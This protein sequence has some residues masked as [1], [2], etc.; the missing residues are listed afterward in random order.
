[1][2]L[3]NLKIAHKLS[4]AFGLVVLLFLLLAGIVHQQLGKVLFSNTDRYPKI[5]MINTI[6]SELGEIA[7]YQRDLLLLSSATEQTELLAKIDRSARVVADTTAQLDP[8]IQLAEGRTLLRAFLDTRNKAIASRTAF[9]EQVRSQKTEEARQTLTGPVRLAMEAQ[10]GAADALLDFQSKLMNESAA[11][12]A[13]GITAAQTSMAVLCGVA[14]VISAGLAFLLTRLIAVPLRKAVEVAR[15]VAAG[16]L[17]SVIVAEGQDETGQLMAA[18]DSMNAALIAIVADVR[19]SAD[20]VTT[21][22]GEIAQGNLDLSSRTE[23]QAS[24]LEETASS[25][26]ELTS[27]VKQNADNARQANQMAASA[28][29]VAQQ[30]GATVGEVVRTMD[31]ISAASRRIVDIIAV[32]DGI[33]FQTNILALNAAVEAARAGEQGRGFAVVA[34]EVR[35]L[36]Q[37]SAAA[38]KEI[39]G[40]I[41]DSVAQVDSGVQQV[42]RAG[43]TMGQIVSGIERVADIMNEISAASREQESGIGEIN[44]AVSAMDSV[45]QQ[46]AALVEEAAAAAQSLRE[47][48]TALSER[49]SV[50]KLSGET[51]RTVLAMPV[52]PALRAPGAAPAPLRSRPALRAV[53]GEWDEF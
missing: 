2:N 23:Q 51:T 3:R 16:D 44:A 20:A 43:D 52:R 34:S 33:A 39:K 50:F 15:T 22:S 48:A 29:Q 8:L 19:Q 5:V 31:A 21:A 25:M 11:E 10:L 46:N 45:T 14:V 30:G 9:L 26:E 47:Q 18:L 12:A 42:G 4:L 32:I 37:R 41:D 6:K 24:A 17:T 36:A 38:A 13:R 40:L 53:N 1:M 49:V 7:R 35:N 27:T 28:A